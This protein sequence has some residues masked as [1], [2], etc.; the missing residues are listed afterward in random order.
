MSFLECVMAPQIAQDRERRI[1][2]IVAAKVASIDDDGMYRL[3]YLSMGDGAPSAPARVMTPMAGDGRGMHFFPE[4]GDEVVVA[5]EDG[6]P[7]LPIILG[8][9][10][11]G[12]SKVP[13]QAD[14]SPTNNRRTIVSR[15]GHELTFDDTVAKQKVTIRSQGG[16]T[17]VLDDA[18][19]KGKVTIR[20]GTGHEIE[21][22]DA[23]P[24]KV[25]V[26]NSAGA[27]VTL[28]N[29]GGAVTI[30]ALTVL[31]L[32][33]GVAMRLEAPMGITLQTTRVPIASLVQIDGSLYGA[34]TH[35][36]APPAT[37]GPLAT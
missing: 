4:P 15:S 13:G 2:G 10:W 5:F 18:P 17:I 9:V 36:L 30:E 27:K 20:S 12:E 1:S 23:P 31:T 19:G 37:T 6:D 33:A 29:A 24:G 22:D 3:E 21:L 11:N 26:R 7:S 35:F 16:H 14:A 25:T 28:D 8:A 32:K 34:H